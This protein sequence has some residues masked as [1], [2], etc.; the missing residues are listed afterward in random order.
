MVEVAVVFIVCC[1]KLFKAGV[2]NLPLLFSLGFSF[3]RAQ[4]S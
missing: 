1:A 2:K 4:E 3:A